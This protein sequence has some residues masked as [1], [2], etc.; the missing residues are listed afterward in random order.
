MSWLSKALHS[1]TSVIKGLVKP[2]SMA[3]SGIGPGWSNSQANSLGAG[4]EQAFKTGFKDVKSK[5]DKIF[6]MDKLSNA[7]W[8]KATGQNDPTIV[9]A[10]G[11]PSNTTW[12]K[13]QAANPNTDLTRAK[14]FTKIGDSIAGFY[15]GGAVAGALGGGGSAG[16]GSGVGADLTGAGAGGATGGVAGTSAGI[17][18]ATGATLAPVVV[19][20]SNAIAPTVAGAAAAGG[21]AASSSSSGEKTDW[22]SKLKAAGAGLTSGSQEDQNKALDHLASVGP[23]PQVNMPQQNLG[24]VDQ[25]R[26]LQNPQGKPN[27]GLGTSLT[28][29]Y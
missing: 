2:S 15:G 24:L 29:G 17:G 12:E 23:P 16:A 14:D 10:F 1:P 9:N 21:S 18:G 3:D 11:S 7:I 28:G 22:M 26:Q 19:T 8:N 27:P 6:H 4:L 20:G 25:Y 13:T 5:P